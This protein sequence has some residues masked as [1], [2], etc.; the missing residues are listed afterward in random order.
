M[1]DWTM[2]KD[3]E[4]LTRR[5]ERAHLLAQ[6]K[7]KKEDDGKSAGK[8]APAKVLFSQA[9]PPAGG[10]HEHSPSANLKICG[11]NNEF[12]KCEGCGNVRK[13]ARVIPCT[14]E[15]RYNEHPDFNKDWKTKPFQRSAFLTWKGFRERFPNITKLPSDLLAWETRSAAYQAKQAKKR[16]A[17]DNSPHPN[18]R[19]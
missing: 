14:P 1:R 7:S 12:M 4:T 9:A 11:K 15:C 5:N 19:P 18:K 13:N 2:R 17:P 10:F 3:D 6:N 8:T 16:P